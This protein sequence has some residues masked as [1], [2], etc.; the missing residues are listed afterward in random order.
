MKGAGVTDAEYEQGGEAV[1]AGSDST[2][3]QPD[4]AHAHSADPPMASAGRP[5]GGY[6][7]EGYGY[8][9]QPIPP[10]RPAGGG[11]A[12]L[13][14]AGAIALVVVLGVGIAAGAWIRG[15]G[16]Q[17]T[18][19]VSTAPPVYSMAA[20]TNACDIVD[21][22]PLTKWSAN[23]KGAPTHEEAR[24]SFEGAGGL[25]CDVAYTS[26]PDGQYSFDTIGM[27]LAAE[28]TNG[29]ASPF[30]DHWKHL[31]TITRA[32]PGTATGAV[33]G[34]GAQGYW[35]S[36]IAEN[37]TLRRAYIVCVQD[38]NV[39]VRAKIDLSR[40][41]KLGPAPSW[42]ELDSIARAQVRLALN[43]LKQK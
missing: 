23:P 25:S 28:F 29:T 5:A 26:A 15:R 24:P 41:N 32:G 42:D 22:T 39:S 40:D 3:R 1:R 17:S 11:K 30:Y 8:R 36:E 43:A 4:P 31:D 19:A 33:T 16:G 35:S 27:N 6:G 10:Q 13:V 2:G 9:P 14:V 20:V 38:G 7:P 37:L 18:G 12:G 34:V 21:P